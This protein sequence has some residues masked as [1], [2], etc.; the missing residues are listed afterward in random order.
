MPVYYNNLRR[1]KCNAGSA[2][3]ANGDYAF[4]V[5]CQPGIYNFVWEGTADTCT[6]SLEVQSQTNQTGTDEV[7][8]ASASGIEVDSA[9]TTVTSSA[10]AVAVTL[11]YGHYQVNLSSVGAGTTMRCWLTLAMQGLQG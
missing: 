6:L 11:G 10:G 4:A 3:T 5:A 2:M 7:P 9:N 1:I 8:V